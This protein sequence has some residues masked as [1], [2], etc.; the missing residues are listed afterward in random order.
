MAAVNGLLLEGLDDDSEDDE[1]YRSMEN[2]APV[3]T[4]EVININKHLLEG[5][6]YDKNY[7]EIGGGDDDNE[8]YE[9][10]E[11]SSTILAS[12]YYNE[13]DGC[14]FS[15]SFPLAPTDN[16]VAVKN[17][18]NLSKVI[19]DEYDEDIKSDEKWQSKMDDAVL[20][21][22]TESNAFLPTDDLVWQSLARELLT[23]DDHLCHGTFNTDV[24]DNKNLSSCFHPLLQVDT[25]NAASVIMVEQFLFSQ[26]PLSS[27]VFRE[28]KL[29]AEERNNVKLSN[30]STSI[31]TK[32]I[33]III[34]DAKGDEK[35]MELTFPRQIWVD[36]IFHP[37]IVI[38]IWPHTSEYSLIFSTIASLQADVLTATCHLLQWG[39]ENRNNSTVIHS[40]SEP[41]SPIRIGCIDTYLLQCIAIELFS[42]FKYRVIEQENVSLFVLSSSVSNGV[43]KLPEGYEYLNLRECDAEIINDMWMYKSTHS[44][45]KVEYSMTCVCC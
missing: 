34:N 4:N 27:R 19:N 29:S 26:L 2:A 30:T 33:E 14:L 21:G 42:S 24:T 3:D 41:F 45:K 16:M 18:D 25:N 8:W 12:S 20:N 23:N 10:M 39:A 6:S 31:G 22:Q 32:D 9:Q 37:S 11:N 7:S 28:L 38:V 13:D 43:D 35:T 36:D 5:A 15:P 1:W 40:D 44:I 17:T